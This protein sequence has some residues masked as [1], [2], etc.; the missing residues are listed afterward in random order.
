M[1]DYADRNFDTSL[2]P[3]IIQKVSQAADTARDCA[4]PPAIVWV[5]DEVLKAVQHLSTVSNEK[6]PAASLPAIR[7]ILSSSDYIDYLDAG[8]N[9]CPAAWLDLINDSRRQRGD[10]ILA[11]KSADPIDPYSDI[12]SIP[13]PKKYSGDAEIASVY[14]SIKPMLTKCIKSTQESQSQ[15]ISAAVSK[16]LLKSAEITPASP[17]RNL[18]W[19][20]SIL[21]SAVAEGTV[22][23]TPGVN[24]AL[25][26]ASACIT[27]LAKSGP[28]AKSDHAAAFAVR[29]VMD[30]PFF[31]QNPDLFDATFHMRSGTAEDEEEIRHVKDVLRG[32]SGKTI[33]DFKSALTDAL[34]MI[35]SSPPKNDSDMLESLNDLRRSS[36]A[37][38][39]VGM[40][41]ESKAIDELIEKAMAL[42]D[43][44]QA[45]C[46]AVS[47]EVNSIMA[48]LDEKKR[49]HGSIRTI[50]PGST[51]K[52]K[53]HHQ[54][55][56]A[57]SV[58]FT[59]APTRKDENVSVIESEVKTE[60]ES[61][62]TKS[63]D[64]DF[65]VESNQQSQAS[66]EPS[67]E[68]EQ[69]Q[70]PQLSLSIDEPV[71]MSL[72]VIDA[73]ASSEPVQEE[74]KK[75]LK[76]ESLEK[77]VNNK[78]QSEMSLSLVEMEMPENKPDD[79]S[80]SAVDIPGEFDL[81]LI[82]VQ[83]E[84]VKI[85]I[86]ADLKNTAAVNN[87]QIDE[88]EAKKETAKPP[89]TSLHADYDEDVLWTPPAHMQPLMSEPSAPNAQEDVKKE[90]NQPAQT[91]SAQP[92][93]IASGSHPAD[94]VVADLIS[95]IASWSASKSNDELISLRNAAKQFVEKSKQHI[96]AETQKTE[97][98]AEW[99]PMRK[100]QNTQAKPAQEQSTSLFGKIKGLMKKD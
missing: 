21:M 56:R 11:S 7:M 73:H 93:V 69:E 1:Q 70:A 76:E 72:E 20:V 41:N 71:S 97:V 80:L 24:K 52:Q 44:V 61:Q 42:P 45:W 81:N 31:S 14:R 57:L 39:I 3:G 88:P 75:E 49:R 59:A 4:A 89:S 79:L 90:N 23:R 91:P 29:R 51:P 19:L 54:Q 67:Q 95:A 99:A 82:S 43:D 37:L 46:S 22:P 33:G 60:A 78:F 32:V 30:L 83:S 13:A 58:D 87:N 6:A 68:K 84:E 50:V 8:N 12:P 34:S 38:F 53:H 40:R 17:T 94:G 18:L 48:T 47:A 26:R 35:M 55:E 10:A 98:E 27:L 100:G 28:K 25:F 64:N 74:L 86:P 62:P 63:L 66:L 2:I 92:A 15:A 5:M 9:D 85:D 16:L 36:A 96:T 77:P 65:N